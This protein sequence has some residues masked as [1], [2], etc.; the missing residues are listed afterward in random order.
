MHGLLTFYPDRRPALIAA[1]KKF[2]VSRFAELL[3]I[4]GFVILAAHYSTAEVDEILSRASAEPASGLVASATLLIALSALLKS[5][6]LPFHGWLMQ[7]ME[8]PTPVSALLHAGVINLGGFVLLRFA[9]LVSESTAA[10]TLLIAV[11]GTT[12]A[13]AAAVAMS[14]HSVKLALAWSTCAQMGFML[15]QCGLGLYALAWLHMLG[16]AVYKASKFL[17]AGERVRQHVQSAQ[18]GPLAP[19]RRPESALATLAGVATVGVGF[20][21]WRLDPLQHPALCLPGLVLALGTAGNMVAGLQARMPAIVV[22]VGVASVAFAVA[23]LGLH[24]L[25]GKIFGTFAGPSASA[26]WAALWVAVLFVGLHYLHLLANVHYGRA[27]PAR[28]RA[29]LE[30]GFYLDEYLS[31]LAFRLWPLPAAARPSS[32]PLSTRQETL[33]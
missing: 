17:G 15:L 29:L 32:V 7:V 18:A 33:G 12:A 13:A 3:L 2:L 25:L 19:L 1:H 6:Q 26:L 21:A 10:S 24:E 4:S 8:A 27:V 14:R 30:A 5:A 9:P 22:R 31:R 20:Y 11:G 16:H 28:L 23:Y